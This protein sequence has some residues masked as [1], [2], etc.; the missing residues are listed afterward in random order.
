MKSSEEPTS[1]S[2][3]SSHSW[4]DLLVAARGGDEQALG[5]IC[6]RLYGYLL[7]VAR[8]GIGSDLAAKV[9][10]SDVVQQSLMEAHEDFSRFEGAT[11]EEFRA[12]IGMLLRRNLQDVGRRYRGAAR[13]NVAREI[14][15]DSERILP[16]ASPDPNASRIARRK[17]TDEELA[18]AVEG[19]PDRQRRIVEL[20]HRDNISYEQIA[21]RLDITPESARKQYS[22][23]VR[24]LKQQLI[25]TDDSQA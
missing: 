4:D 13:R 16:I 25:P 17:E 19:L 5:A 7:V 22:R 15:L 6:E 8:R 10:A 20:R 14:G 11:E 18:R 12:W 21:T 9:G 3:Q 23:A 1:S 2:K 24:K